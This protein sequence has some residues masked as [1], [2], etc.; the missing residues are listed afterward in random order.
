MARSKGLRHEG[1]Q[2]I[3]LAAQKVPML[4]T[5]RETQMGGES[6]REGEEEGDEKGERGLC[7]FGEKLHEIR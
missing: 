3:R 6:E 7:R 2:K 1:W 4:E 5:K